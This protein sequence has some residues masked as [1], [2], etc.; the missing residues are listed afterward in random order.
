VYQQKMAE[1]I[2]RV[3]AGMAL[4]TGMGR[5]C[6]AILHNALCIQAYMNRSPEHMRLARID[7]AIC[8]RFWNS[9]V[10]SKPDAPPSAATDC[11]PP[12]AHEDI[13]QV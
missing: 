2:N 5:G 13:E 3:V 8:L 12:T 6:S 4:M 10:F 11:L 9:V 1:T 7:F